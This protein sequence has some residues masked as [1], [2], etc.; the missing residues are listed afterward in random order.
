MALSKI[1]YEDD[2]IEEVKIFQVHVVDHRW[3]SIHYPIRRQFRLLKNFYASPQW[4]IMPF[5][6]FTLGCAFSYVSSK[7]LG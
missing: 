6:L 7:N 4:E 2:K 3:L 5:L 1:T